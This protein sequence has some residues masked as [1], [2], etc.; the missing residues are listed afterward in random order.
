MGMWLRMPCYVFPVLCVQGKRLIVLTKGGVK[1]NPAPASLID[2]Y[3]NVVQH[4]RPRGLLSTEEE[5]LLAEQVQLSRQF[6]DEKDRLT[7]QL[8]RAPSNSEWAEACGQSP[9]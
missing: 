1:P 6:L 8:G 4:V 9:E 7:E 2:L 3:T 5:K